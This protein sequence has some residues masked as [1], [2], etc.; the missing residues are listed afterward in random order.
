[1]EVIYH[2]MIYGFPNI[3]IL[4]SDLNS[5]QSELNNNIKNNKSPEL[6]NNIINKETIGSPKLY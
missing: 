3:K 5:T 4:M 6:N 2:Y 1:M